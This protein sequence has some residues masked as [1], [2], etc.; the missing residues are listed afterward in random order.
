MNPIQNEIDAYEHATLV[1]DLEQTILFVNQL[2]E[3]LFGYERAELINQ[4]LDLLIPERFHESH[5]VFFNQ[6]IQS[7]EEIG[8]GSGLTM[9]G[10]QKEGEEFKINTKLEIR[11][12]E[13]NQLVFCSIQKL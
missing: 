4:K 2:M 6:Y 12:V 13:E 11:T 7:P 1:V 10:L 5:P 8:E 3:Q 9:W